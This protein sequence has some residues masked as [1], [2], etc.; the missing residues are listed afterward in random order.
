MK[1]LLSLIVISFYSATAS[2]VVLDV[3]G[4]CSKKPVYSGIFK[5][6]ISESIGK[7]SVDIFEANKIPYIGSENGMNSI[8]NSPMGDEAIEVL[9]NTKMRVHGWCFSINGIIPD[10][11]ADK[12]HV[13]NQSD[14]IS[15]FYAFSTYDK[16]EWTDYCIPSYTVKSPQFC[17]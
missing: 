9:S 2:A 7:I 3:I 16:G 12:I 8:I 10:V 13:T 15:W 11:T 5:T 1:T 6:D 17:K 4:A 14:Y